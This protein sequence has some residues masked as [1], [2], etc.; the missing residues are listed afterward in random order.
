MP[1]MA[2]GDADRSLHFSWDAETEAK[3]NQ[4][5]FGESEQFLAPSSGE[6]LHVQ[7]RTKGLRG[8]F[9]LV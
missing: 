1:V 6:T 3:L 5:F 7:S 2:D 4:L 9:L 8:L